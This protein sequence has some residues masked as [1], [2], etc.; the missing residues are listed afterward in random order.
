MALCIEHI[1]GANIKENIKDPPH[2]HLQGVS[3]GVQWIL[4]FSQ[5][6]KETFPFHT[7]LPKK[8][9]TQIDFKILSHQHNLRQFIYS[10]NVRPNQLKTLI[11]LIKEI[12]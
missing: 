12:P 5:P 11:Q 10:S 1:V 6:R 8:S 3:S 9:D 4:W 2:W 7:M